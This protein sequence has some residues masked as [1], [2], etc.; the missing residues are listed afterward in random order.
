MF[1]PSSIITIASNKKEKERR[2]RIKQKLKTW[3]KVVI[4]NG[5]TELVVGKFAVEEGE[6]KSKV[7]QRERKENNKHV[8]SKRE[9]IESN[10]KTTCELIVLEIPF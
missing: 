2:K 8:N 5:S 6:T 3:R 4:G 7:L 10:R 1:F 9:L